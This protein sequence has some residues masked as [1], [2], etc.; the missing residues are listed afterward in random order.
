M[1][2]MSE[3]RYSSELGINL[4]SVVDNPQM[5][6]QTFTASEISTTEPDADLFQP[7]HGYQIVDHRKPIPPVN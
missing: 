1:S 2:I 7:P 6:R 4:F 5:G 3:F